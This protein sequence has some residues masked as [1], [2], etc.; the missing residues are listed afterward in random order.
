MFASAVLGALLLPLVAAVSVSVNRTASS[1]R[2]HTWWHS[3]GEYNSQTPVL[4]GNVRQSGNFSVQVS[5]SSNTS[6]PSSYYDSFVYETIPR[7]GMGNIINPLDP[8]ILSTNDDG[9][10]IESAIGMTMAWTSFLYSEDVSIKITRLDGGSTAAGNVIIH[11]TTLDYAKTEVNGDIYITVPYSNRGV[12]FSVEFTDNLYE[13]HSNC[14]I[15]CTVGKQ[16]LESSFSYSN[17]SSSCKISFGP[18]IPSGLVLWLQ[19]L[20]CSRTNSKIFIGGL[21]QNTNPSGESYWQEPF[22]SRNPVVGIEPLNSLLIFASPFP[23]PDMVPDPTSPTSFVVEP[24][25]VTDVN[26]TDKNTVSAFCGA[27]FP[28]STPCLSRE[29]C[30]RSK[31]LMLLMISVLQTKPLASE[32]PC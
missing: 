8:A 3:T 16:D 12:R 31:Q 1:S 27:T 21:V 13:F 24:G 7:N 2:L 26:T 10:T 32:K 19:T 23:P 25:L 20:P 11:P 9:I 17:T 5:T 22:D 29:A 28:Q 6:D 30:F 4:D 18:T 15:S 14:A